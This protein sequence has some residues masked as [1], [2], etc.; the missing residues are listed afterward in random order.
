MPDHA[1]LW[2]GDTPLHQAGYLTD[3]LGDHAVSA[4]EGFARLDRPFLLS[5][6][7]SAPHWPWEGPTD[8]AESKR[9]ERATTVEQMKDFDGGSQATYAAMVERM[10]QQ[11]GRVLG[12]LQRLGL[13]GN[14]IVIFTSDN[15]GERFADTW[16]FTGRKTELLEGGIRIPSILR[17]PGRTVAGA[18]SDAQI[19]SMDWLPTLVALAGTRPNR[20]Y[21]P[22]GVDLAP[23]LAGRPLPQRTLFWRYRQNAQRACRQGDWKYLKIRENE[24]LFNVAADPLER[25]NLKAREPRRFAALKRAWTAWNATMRPL[26]PAA[27]TDGFDG[28]ELADHFGVSS[29]D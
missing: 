21:P 22:D 8:A 15:G 10:D 6:H 25:A 27:N 20:S 17:W 14:T 19:I 9:L 29:D 28:G 1:D 23:A 26:D 5:L 2:D 18:S 12:A 3:L 13:A 4:L 24:F 11:V 16:P 7:F